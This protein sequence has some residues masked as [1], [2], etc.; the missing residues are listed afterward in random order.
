MVLPIVRVCGLFGPG[1]RRWCLAK[2]MN[3]SARVVPCEILPSIPRNA[4]RS[5]SVRGDSAAVG[6]LPVFVG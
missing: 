2:G 4:L 5:P 1:F 3:F 6:G